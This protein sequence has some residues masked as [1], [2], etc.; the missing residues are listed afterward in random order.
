[1]AAVC[2]CVGT[3][4]GNGDPTTRLSALERSANPAPR[5]ITDIH[6]IREELSIKLGAYTEV[7]VR[8]IL[9]NASAKDYKNI[10]YA[11]PIDYQGTGE[12]FVNSGA[13]PDSYSES[14]GMLGWHDD[15]IKDV[16]FFSNG[17]WLPF[18]VSPEIVIAKPDGPV[19]QD[20][21]E[22]ADF[23]PWSEEEAAIAYAYRTVGRKWFYT[24]FSVRAGETLVLDVRYSLR[25]SY[26]L[27][28]GAHLNKKGWWRISDFYYDMSPA[29]HWGNGKARDLNIEV[30][31]SGVELLGDGDEARYQYHYP[32]DSQSLMFAEENGKLV[33]RATNFDFSAAQ[34]IHLLYTTKSLPSLEEWLPYR[35][36]NDR[37]TVTVSD[38]NASYPASNL[39]DMDLQIA[40]A[41]PWDKEGQLWI[42]VK[43]REPVCL[44][45]VLLLGGYHKSEKT[46]YENCRPGGKMIMTANMLYE[47]GERPNV[48][49]AEE[50]TTWSTHFSDNAKVYRPVT[51][52]NFLDN[53]ACVE[54]HPWGGGSLVT[55]L[56]LC[57]YDGRYE[58]YEIVPG[59][60]Y[61]DVCVS[62]LI[63]L[64]GKVL[65]HRRIDG[66]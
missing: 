26:D 33:F 32:E 40:W 4:R 8:Y 58:P 41:V 60:K 59:S 55:E 46:F 30:D 64:D 3:A 11:F 7:S 53:A 9:W 23:G 14:T 28:A 66:E 62:E 5:T 54:M 29:A 16:A 13:I 61:N 1:M 18:E 20:E 25:N 47:T 22:L 43:F 21:D 57:I 10:D 65:P 27:A 35:I 42:T 34:P 19:V 38:E 31:L 45:A 48:E 36:G 50:S 6:V 15:Y 24:Q 56:T 49:F 63:L 2:C 37:Y 12:R 51:F 44:G 17:K 52:D 39:T